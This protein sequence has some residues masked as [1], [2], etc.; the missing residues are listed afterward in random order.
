MVPLALHDVLGARTLLF[1][2]HAKFLLFFLLLLLQQVRDKSL[3]VLLFILK[4]H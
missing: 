3:L 1:L 4:F 2:A